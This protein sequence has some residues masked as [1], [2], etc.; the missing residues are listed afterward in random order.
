MTHEWALRMTG[1]LAALHRAGYIK[2]ESAAF[3]HIAP[4]VPVKKP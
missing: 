3:W 1:Y 2:V 4:P